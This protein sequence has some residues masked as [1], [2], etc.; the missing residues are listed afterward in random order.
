MD[1]T[2]YDHN[3]LQMTAVITK[4]FLIFV[5]PGGLEYSKSTFTFSFQTSFY[6]LFTVIF[7]FHSM[8]LWMGGGMLNTYAKRNTCNL[9][10]V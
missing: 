8:L 9:N 7:S 6:S 5:L 10:Q 1:R 3:F 4:I 2:V